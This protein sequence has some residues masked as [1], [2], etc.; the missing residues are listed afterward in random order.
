MVYMLDLLMR[1]F[2]GLITA[3]FRLQLQVPCKC[4]YH[5]AGHE[6]CPRVVEVQNVLATGCVSTGANDIH[7]RFIL[8]LIHTILGEA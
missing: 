4:V 5:R 8:G 3:H 1:S 2:R 6:S 7:L